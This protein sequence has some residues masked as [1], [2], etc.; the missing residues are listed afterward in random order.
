MPKWKKDR[1]WDNPSQALQKL[2]RRLQILITPGMEFE[3][4]NLLKKGVF[5]NISEMGRHCIRIY[6]DRY[7]EHEKFKKNHFKKID[8]RDVEELK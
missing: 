8:K 5:P 4:R 2:S 3:M 7:V 1:E 6:I